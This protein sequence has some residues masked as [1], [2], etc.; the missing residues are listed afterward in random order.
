M[1]QK[2]RISASHKSAKRIREHII[3]S[4]SSRTRR[5]CQYPPCGKS[6]HP[7]RY[8]QRFCSDKC[9]ADDWRSHHP[10]TYEPKPFK[11]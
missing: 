8:W 2:P 1:E 5:K 3:V 9:K 6:Y 11:D 7:K 10:M 4:V